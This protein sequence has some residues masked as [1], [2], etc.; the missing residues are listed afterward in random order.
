M[1]THTAH[2]LLAHARRTDGQLF[3]HLES[4]GIHDLPAERLREIDRQT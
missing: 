4:I 1:M 2:F 3:V